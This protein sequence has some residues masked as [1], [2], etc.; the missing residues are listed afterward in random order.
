MALDKLRAAS[1]ELRAVSK[2][3]KQRYNKVL[4]VKELEAQSWKPIAS[5]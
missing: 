5:L 3:N 1:F 2:I 4:S